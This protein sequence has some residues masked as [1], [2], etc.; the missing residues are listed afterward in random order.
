MTKVLLIEDEHAQLAF[1]MTVLRQNGF[2]VVGAEDGVQGIELALE[3]LPDLIICDIHL[4]TMDGYETLAAIR[5]DPIT[6]TTPFILVT[7]LADRQGMRQGMEL[8]ADDYLPKPFTP[9]ELVSVVNT[10]LQKHRRVTQQA[11]KKLEDLR[12][13]MSAMMPHELRTPLNGILGYA[14]LMRKQ[15]EDLQPAEV[16][17]MAER[18]YKNAKRLQRLI[19]NYLLYAR[20][21]LQQSPATSGEHHDEQLTHKVGEIIDHTGRVKAQEFNRPADLSMQLV[22]GTVAVPTEFFTKIVEE[23]LDNAFR[24]SKPGT[25]VHVSCAPQKYGF[26]FICADQGRGMTPRQIADIGA[27]VQFDRKIYEQ[28]GAGLGLTVV[29]RLAKIHGGTME[30][31]STPGSGSTVTVIL[32]QG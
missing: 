5:N 29:S 6:A 23:V 16:A 10:R 14:D 31:R 19:E 26:G 12:V 25:T 27:F 18:V 21:E 9:A 2:E 20:L 11:G 22:D 32:P 17:K 13:T 28:Q 30:I 4:V 3:H 8:G 1:M 24:Y 15:S 7:G